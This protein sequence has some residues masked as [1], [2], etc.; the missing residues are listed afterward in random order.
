MRLAFECWRKKKTFEKCCLKPLIASLQLYPTERTLVGG[1]LR[2]PSSVVLHVIQRLTAKPQPS[3]RRSNGSIVGYR[4]IAWRPLWRCEARAAGRSSMR[5]AGR[6]VDARAPWCWLSATSSV[7]LH[8]KLYI[9]RSPVNQGEGT[10]RAL[11]IE[12]PE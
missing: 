1:K 3:T 11:V 10:A 12:I 7:M 9:P 2:W 4:I 6:G 8:P 5:P